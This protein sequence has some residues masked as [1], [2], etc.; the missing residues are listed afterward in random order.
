MEV[1]DHQP[2]GWFLL[3]DGERYFLDVNARL[4]LVDIS[5]FLELDG[6]ERAEYVALGR[7]F[8]EYLAAKV[9]HWPSRY[10]SRDVTGPLAQAAA[11]AIDH[12]GQ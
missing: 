8:V 6:E 4:P 5:I 9:S 1:V 12:C 3:R 10:R 11:Q 7:T 2:H